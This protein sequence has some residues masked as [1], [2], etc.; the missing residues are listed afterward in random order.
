MRGPNNTIQPPKNKIIENIYSRSVVLNL[1]TVGPIDIF[2]KIF[3]PTNIF[4]QGLYVL[5][6]QLGLWG[7][8]LVKKIRLSASFWRKKNY[9]KTYILTS[10][11]AAQL[12]FTG[13]IIQQRP[14]AKMF[15]KSR[16][17]LFNTHAQSLKLVSTILVGLIFFY[18]FC[19]VIN[20]SGPVTGT[21]P[22]GWEMLL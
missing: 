1:W 11:Q 5:I 9:V 21:G 19:T 8:L 3:G 10:K 2:F 14:I 15:R 17:I 18:T 6:S 22:S 7:R 4:F 16:F 12:L 20:K 13:Q